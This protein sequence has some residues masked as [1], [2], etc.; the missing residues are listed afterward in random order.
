MSLPS[1]WALLLLEWLVLGPGL[2]DKVA[3]DMLVVVV[4]RNRI[5][6]K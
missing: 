6:P 4:W 1:E 3:E 2:E 5:A